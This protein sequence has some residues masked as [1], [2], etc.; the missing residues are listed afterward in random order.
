[1]T[2]ELDRLDPVSRLADDG[3]A[4]VRLQDPAQAGPYERLVVGD[5]HTHGH[6]S[7]RSSGK[8]ARTTKPPVAPGEAENSPP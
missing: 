3:N 1:M 7:D 4:V 2:R 6:C 8:R 5:D